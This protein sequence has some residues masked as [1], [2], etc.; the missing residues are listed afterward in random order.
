[1]PAQIW[2][3]NV[4]ETWMFNTRAHQSNRLM[5]VRKK[6]NSRDQQHNNDSK[7]DDNRNNKTINCFRLHSYTHLLGGKK[8]IQ[9]NKIFHWQLI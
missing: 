4:K 7:K 1:M 6:P 5:Y 9:G 8:I 3:A 2:A